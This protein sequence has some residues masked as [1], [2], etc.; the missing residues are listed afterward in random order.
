VNGINKIRLGIRRQHPDAPNPLRL[1][2]A[3]GQRPCRRRTADKRD[4][5]APPHT[6][7]PD[8][9]VIEIE[10]VGAVRLA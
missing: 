3:R 10:A 1:L 4:E 5:L 7:L 8:L 6:A 9:E 2:R